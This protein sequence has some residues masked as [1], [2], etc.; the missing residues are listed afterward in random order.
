MYY[1]DGP[2]YLF[3]MFFLLFAFAPKACEK[4]PNAN[5]LIIQLLFFEKH[6][7]I[8]LVW[9]YDHIGMRQVQCFLL[10]NF[11]INILNQAINKKQ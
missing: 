11:M 4:F 3:R 2:N 10:Y 1:S 8:S 7:Y 5:I 6:Q 9:N